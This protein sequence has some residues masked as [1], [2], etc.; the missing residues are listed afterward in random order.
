MNVGHQAFT[1][2]YLRRGSE[3]LG[4]RRG[5]DVRPGVPSG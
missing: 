5:L 2:A 3:V 1:H 4:C